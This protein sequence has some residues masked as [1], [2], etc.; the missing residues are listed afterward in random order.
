MD[1]AS[2][3]PGA[4]IELYNEVNVVFMSA[5]KTSTMQLMNQRVILTFKSYYLRH[6]SCKTRAAIDS[7]SSDGSWQSKSKTFLEGF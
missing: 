7:D 3:H 6:L 2:V 5:N 1:D 4:L